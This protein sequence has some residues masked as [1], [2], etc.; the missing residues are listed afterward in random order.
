[1]EEI[2]KRIEQSFPEL[3][4]ILYDPKEQTAYALV[5]GHAGRI[6]FPFMIDL[7]K[8]ICSEDPEEEIRKTIKGGI[9]GRGE[10]V[11]HDAEPGRAVSAPGDQPDRARDRLGAVQSERPDQG[12]MEGKRKNTDGNDQRG[13]ESGDRF[14]YSK[15]GEAVQSTLHGAGG[16]TRRRKDRNSGTG[17]RT[18]AYEKRGREGSC[19][20]KEPTKKEVTL[21]LVTFTAL[22]IALAGMEMLTNMDPHPL[23]G[24]MC[25]ALGGTWILLVGIVN[26]RIADDLKEDFERLAEVIECLR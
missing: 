15:N 3:D 4:S 16:G 14:L 26:S 20:M 2:L 12:R 6:R 24:C 5:I 21:A 25:L 1:M 23:A 19:G 7:H 18:L 11:F 10:R 9:R 8:A 13:A 17:K 22:I